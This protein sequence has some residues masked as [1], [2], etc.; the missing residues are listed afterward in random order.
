MEE[1]EKWREKGQEG[2]A[3]LCGERTNIISLINIFL[4]PKTQELYKAEFI[5]TIN[6]HK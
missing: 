5:C 3:S 1:A 6:I 4:S 2:K